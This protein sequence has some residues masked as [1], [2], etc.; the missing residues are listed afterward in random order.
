MHLGSLY[1]GRGMT[2]PFG[3]Q[4]GKFDI[5]IVFLC[6]RVISRFGD[7]PC[8]TAVYFQKILVLFNS[9]HTSV[10]CALTLR[11]PT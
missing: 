7:A 2:D 6:L 10:T 5:W 11:L 9:V 1:L 8:G 3:Y 4:T